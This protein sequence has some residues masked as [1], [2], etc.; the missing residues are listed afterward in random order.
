[1]DINLDELIKE[2]KEKFRNRNHKHRHRNV[3]LNGYR[4]IIETITIEYKMK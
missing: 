2:D 3:Y 1:M 4:I